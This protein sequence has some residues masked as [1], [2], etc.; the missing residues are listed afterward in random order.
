[1]NCGNGVDK[2]KFLLFHLNAN[3]MILC[4]SESLNG[5]KLI[6]P[7]WVTQK[8]LH[9]MGPRKL[10]VTPTNDQKTWDPSYTQLLSK[11]IILYL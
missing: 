10:W 11:G 3:F 8:F 5:I 6:I 7:P 9:L 4:H 1:M 2:H